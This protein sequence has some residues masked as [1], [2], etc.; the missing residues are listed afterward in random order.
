MDRLERTEEFSYLFFILWQIKKYR[1]AFC[2][3][4]VMG[5]SAS[6]RI[7]S[8]IGGY[9][10]VA[11]AGGDRF[12]KSIVDGFLKYKLLGT[13]LRL[14]KLPLRPLSI[15][16]TPF[17]LAK[18]S[19]IGAV[20][21]RKM[22]A[23]G[24][25]RVTF[26]NVALVICLDDA[27]A[28]TD[29]AE[30]ECEGEE[31]SG[32]AADD[33]ADVRQTLWARE[34]AAREAIAAEL[35]ALLGGDDDAVSSRSSSSSAATTPPIGP[36]SSEN[37]NPNPHVAAAAQLQFAAEVLDKLELVVENL[38][39]SVHC[40]SRAVLANAATAPSGSGAPAAHPTFDLSIESISMLRAGAGGAVT[41]LGALGSPPLSSW[42]LTPGLALGD[43][44]VRSLVRIAGARLFVGR[45]VGAVAALS[46]ASY[47]SSPAAS[48]PCSTLARERSTALLAVPLDAALELKLA[49]R[50]PTSSARLVRLRSA[51]RAHH[52]AY[53]RRFDAAQLREREAR[54]PRILRRYRGRERELW[55]RMAEKYPTARW[56]AAHGGGRPSGAIEEDIGGDGEVELPLVAEDM[57]GETPAVNADVSASLNVGALDLCLDRYAYADL[58]DALHAIGAASSSSHDGADAAA[59]AAGV[60]ADVAADSSLASSSTAAATPR[61]L[62]QRGRAPILTTERE[63]AAACA[64]ACGETSS[65]LG[66][67]PRLMRPTPL[68]QTTLLRIA[69][70]IGH[71]VGAGSTLGARDGD[72]AAED[73]AVPSDN[74]DDD[75]TSMDDEGGGGERSV[76][77]VVSQLAILADVDASGTASLASLTAAVRD[78]E[79]VRDDA[80]AYAVAFAGF[81]STGDAKL[82]VAD[83]A[84]LVGAAIDFDLGAPA[85]R[86]KLFSVELDSIASTAL[87]VTCM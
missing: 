2:E 10:D 74:G 84:A 30:V 67:L 59:A 13:E 37:P 56:P 19:S 48:T 41:P 51:Y 5:S 47:S 12:R 65:A 31:D 70:G 54:C 32:A 66:W 86:Y 27:A 57:E 33:G 29:D 62:Q 18:G 78:V 7:E 69:R 28:P 9:I 8:S 83:V 42:Q 6:S 68:D 43:D 50:D 44:I 34:A 81:D 46:P 72:L 26:S 36:A 1:I 80:A 71:V 85:V 15:R 14:T 49:A 17:Y 11:A 55:R 82:R 52:V 64:A 58:L 60:G 3:I 79:R 20:A 35:A 40:C 25:R 39:I 61:R 38:S 77:S 24:R 22:G 45:S 76:E 87:N 63:V 4:A 21:V 53:P 23:K 75:E 16:G 73:D